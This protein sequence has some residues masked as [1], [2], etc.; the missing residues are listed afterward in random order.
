MA[1]TQKARY[2]QVTTPAGKDFL[3]L[4]EFHASEAV[5]ELFSFELDLVH[6]E[7]ASDASPTII[8]PEKM[9]GQPVCVK[10]RLLSDKEEEEARFF[11]GIVSY[12]QQRGKIRRFTNY[13]AL[14][15]P[16]VWLL[17]Q[18]CQSRIFQRLT[19]PEI[20]E[21]VLSGFDVKFELVG[22]FSKR[23]YC[24]QYQESDFDFISRLMEEEGI[25]YYFEHSKNKHLMIVAN[26]PQ[27]HR[28]CPDKAV[29]PFHINVTEKEGVL[30][31]VRTMEINYNLQT[32][33]T[34][35]W[36]HNFELPH[37][38]LDSDQ[39]TRFQVGGNEKLEQYLHPG[40]YA[41][42]YTGINKAGGNQS[43]EL[44]HI[45]EDNKQQA[46]YRMEALDA[47]YKIFSGNSDCRTLTAGH[48]FKL[49]NH[50][51]DAFNTKYVITR[52]N[53]HAIQ[54]PNL[55]TKEAMPNAYTNS[56]DSILFDGVTFRPPR[57]TPKPK[58]WGSQT[59]V[60][61]GP[62]GEEIFC[63][64]YGR[65]KVQ[66]HWDRQGRNDIDSSCWMRVSQPWAG[67]SWGTIC[68]PR[69][70]QEVIVTFIEGDP[71]RP[72]VSGSVYNPDQMPPYELPGNAN[73]MG[74]KS[75][76]TK[77][78]GGYNEICIVDGKSGELIRVHA[79]KD[80][81]T[82]VLN[83]DRQY[84]V[85][86]RTKKVDGWQ[87]ETVKGDKTTTIT[88]GN[89][90]TT[91]K[92]G[93]HSNTVQQ[94]NQTNKVN[95]GWQKNIVKKNIKIE[96]TDDEILIKAKTK[97]TLQVGDNNITIDDKGNIK[98]TAVTSTDINAKNNHIGGITKIDGGDCFIN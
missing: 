96:S 5:S 43:S 86:N 21:Q 37:K 89:K 1:L 34:T 13:R 88:E 52:I 73:M 39:S 4:N 33:K 16:K 75:N 94:G 17:T 26:T 90:T 70:G 65:I 54:T 92:Q 95:T 29:F 12:W 71:D 22:T 3:I 93:H 87:Q 14:V 47:S 6:E 66:F 79:Q 25:F 51:A 9:L 85:A 44:E 76:S 23:E 55:E 63:D 7:S 61:V 32:G 28:E 11:H 60:V 18:K 27:S 74:F 82:T 59:A 35:L 98:I 30:S 10:V 8:E 42:R 72:I 81:D 38:H 46:K 77:G 49:F 2:L 36:D 56:F 84:V 69:I 48:L 58:I 24:V 45:F 20:L 83:D 40:E 64:K 78:G 41:K 62:A 15:V 68:I 50:P 67:R 91:V 97:I 53:H 57:Q 31:A 80:M 19:V